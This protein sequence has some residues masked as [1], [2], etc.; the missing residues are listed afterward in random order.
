MPEAQKSVLIATQKPF[1]RSARDC[2]VEEMRQAGLYVS[3]LEGYGSASEL[4]EALQGIKGMIV[5]SD[6]IT[7][8]LMR[9]AEQLEIVIRAGAGYDNI[10]VAHAQD[11]GIIVENTPGQNA[12]AVAELAISLMLAAI[13]PLDGSS[14]IELKGKTLGVHGFGNIG[15]IVAR[16]GRAFGMHV[17]VFDMNMDVRRAREY[18]V[19]IAESLEALYDGA[20]VV[21]LHIPE[22]PATRGSVG[23]ALLE[24]MSDNAVLVN[25]ARAGVV[26]E[27][28]LLQVLKERGG[29]RYASDVAPG[30]DTAAAM[31]RD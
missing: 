16:L 5:R 24:R 4:S 15:C 20:D 10:D 1:D 17:R 18:G 29:F 12:N 22:N 2:M 28:E 11:S 26:C 27:S 31:E 19:A 13:R 23:K 6:A 21:S 14:G 25:T 9:G 30:E 7:A 8:D 3:L